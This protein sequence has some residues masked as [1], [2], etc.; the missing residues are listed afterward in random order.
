MLRYVATDILVKI[1]CQ[2]R[3]RFMNRNNKTKIKILN[4]TLTFDFK[5]I[6]LQFQGHEEGTSNQNTLS[7]YY[8][9]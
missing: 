4:M 6:Q 1:F 8:I 9:W 2:Y 5:K 3:I 7:L